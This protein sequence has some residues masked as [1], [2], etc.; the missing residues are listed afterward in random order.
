[1]FIYVIIIYISNSLDLKKIV[2]RNHVG[3]VQ[4]WGGGESL[5]GEGDICNTYPIK[6][7]KRKKKSSA[8]LIFHPH[9]VVCVLTVGDYANLYTHCLFCLIVSKL[10]F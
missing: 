6:I 5:V 8:F 1:M 2:Q 4:E 10:I 9:N 3:R 7:N